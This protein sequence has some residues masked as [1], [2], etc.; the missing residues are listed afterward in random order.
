MSCCA[1]L[2]TVLLPAMLAAP[3]AAWLLA[4]SQC[5]PSHGYFFPR[6]R[7]TQPKIVPPTILHICTWMSR[8]SGPTLVPYQA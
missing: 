3:S 8:T 7:L 6:Y 2:H 5:F 1:A 4:G